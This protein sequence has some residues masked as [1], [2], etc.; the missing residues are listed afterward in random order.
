MTTISTTGAMENASMEMITEA[1]YTIEHNAPIYGTCRRYTLKKG[2]DTGIF[3]KV[4]QMSLSNL[5]EGQDMTDAEEIGLTTVSVTPGEVGAK[6]IVTDKLL[7]QNVA[8]NFQTV[9]RQ[10]GDGYKRKREE[11]IR[12]L[13][14]ALNGG[15]S[16]G[17]ATKSFSVAN[18]TAC[19][20]KAKTDKYGED[21]AIIHHPNAVLRLAQDLTTIGSGQIR[22]IPEGYSAKLIGRAWKGYMIWDTIVL[23]SGNISRD[24]GDDAIGVIKSKEALGFLESKAFGTEKERDASLRGWEVNVV[25][26][27]AAFEL[28]D[29]LGAPLTYDAADPTTVA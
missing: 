5:A 13:F 9:G 25:T 23:D 19:V 14:S 6:V 17:A 28:D 15:T 2:Q 12:D 24:S 10:L 26:D 20:S 3:P 18:A 1:R 16:L 22:P 21:L 11:D 27:Y 29:S 8:V 4:G 7:R